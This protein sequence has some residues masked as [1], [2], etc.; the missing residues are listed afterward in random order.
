MLNIRRSEDRGHVDHGWLN[1]RHTFSFADY[2]D[3]Q[4]M[5]FK[6][7]RVINEDRIQG[8]QGFG[9]HPHR[10]MEIITYLLSGAL[11]HKDSMGSE[12][13]IHPGEFQ[14]M[15][16]GSGVTH[17]E[18]NASKTETAH[19]LQIWIIPS[20]RGLTPRYDQR[21]ISEAQKA[22]TL[23]LVASPDGAADSMQIGQDASL[24]VCKLGRE[25]AVSHSTKPG[26]AY[27]AQVTQGSVLLNESL[28]R[29]GD[30]ATV[31][32]EE[33]LEFSSA[34]GGEFLLFELN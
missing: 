18:Y 20:K 9:T 11:A 28:L 10:D 5:G 24:F 30:A 33:S 15:S 12:A 25:K 3:P 17:S 31:I 29:A 26:K 22:N 1:A 7:L 19:L 21:N 14:F 13:V 32:D 8:G 16:A 23:C 27:W 4:F 2:Y 6:S 34:D